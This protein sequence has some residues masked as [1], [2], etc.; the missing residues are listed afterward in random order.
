MELLVNGK[1]TE[2]EL[3]ELQSLL[4]EKKVEVAP[5]FTKTFSEAE[6]VRL[7]FRDLDA[8]QLLRDGLLFELIQWAV[9]RA[10]KWAKSKKP[11]AKINTSIELHFKDKNGDVNPINVGFPPEEQEAWNQLKESVNVQFIESLDNQEIVNFYWDEK[12]KKLKVQRM[13]I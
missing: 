11:Q 12:D 8:Y 10:Y 6:L 5:Y 7:L 4:Q 1:F 9:I 2:E 13:K 3:A